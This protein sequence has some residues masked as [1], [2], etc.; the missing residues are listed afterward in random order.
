MT[1]PRRILNRFRVF[2]GTCTMVLGL[3]DLWSY[4]VTSTPATPTQVAVAVALVVVGYCVAGLH[5]PSSAD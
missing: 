4:G 5:R 2:A 3:V 1:D